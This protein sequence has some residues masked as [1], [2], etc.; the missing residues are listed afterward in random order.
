M[1]DA[2][3]CA[4]IAALY[5]MLR[6]LEVEHRASSAASEAR[7]PHLAE[8]VLDLRT[9]IARLE[10]AT[11]AVTLNAE[12]P[13]GLAIDRARD[14]PGAGLGLGHTAGGR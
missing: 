14:V 4:Q 9:L 13:A 8:A 1:A 6:R 2:V 5:D 11:P 7:A 10:S 12:L 3:R